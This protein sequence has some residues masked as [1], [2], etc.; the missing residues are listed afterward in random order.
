MEQINSSTSDLLNQPIYAP[1]KRAVEALRSGLM[2]ILVD[3]EDREN[4]GDLVLAAQFATPEQINFMSRNACGL[5]C[6]SLP[7][8][9]IDRLGLYPMARE[10]QSTRKTAFMVSI[11]A[12][13]GVSTGISA[14]DRAHTIQVASKQD[15]T[16][17]DI[18][19]PGHVFPLRAQN[20]G[21][22][23]RAGHTEGS[24]ELCK[25]AGLSSAAV[26]CE[27]MNEDGTMARRDDLDLFSLEHDLP[28]VSIELLT[29]FIKESSSQGAHPIT[30]LRTTHELECGPS[31]KFP[32]KYGEFLM[33][34]YKNIYTGIEHLALVLK[35]DSR[36]K[37]PLVRV[38]SECLTGDV[39][40]SLRCDCGEQ[41]DSS[42]KEISKSGFGALIYLKGQE[43]RG[44]GLYNKIKAYALQDQGYDTLEANVQLG[45]EKDS[46]SYDDAA[47]IL[48]QLQMNQI[49]LISNNPKKPLALTQRGIEVV[50]Q[51]HLK[52]P[53]NPHNRK[54]LE[55][56]RDVLG[57]QLSF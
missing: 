15:A 48:K 4:E 18:Q 49:V 37:F 19:T 17:N 36:Q 45:F 30:H 43:G 34:S 50:E 22:L 54:Y 3:S 21:V 1:L 57:H 12:K 14:A 24:I 47:A 8:T 53:V 42:L 16:R 11:E 7:S 39:F 23:E 2:A 41:L 55:T 31:V 52:T 5:I 40:G 26:I 20:G 6:L 25:L 32:T 56:K 27:I 33:Y 29:Q 9:Q 38:H 46:R 10:N 44:I 51:I 28:I 13:E 35:S